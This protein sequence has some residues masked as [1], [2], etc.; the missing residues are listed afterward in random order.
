MVPPEVRS[1][2][3]DPT[4]RTLDGRT[5]TYPAA[6][7]HP[8]RSAAVVLLLSAMTLL[9]ACSDDGRTLREPLDDQTTTTAAAAG[10]GTGSTEPPGAVAGTN[11]FTVRVD[12][13]LPGES[14]PTPLTCEGEDLAPVVTWQNVPSDAQQLALSMTDPDADGFVHWLVVGLDPLIAGVD[15]ADLPA[16][17]TVLRNGDGEAAWAGPCPS[18]GDPAHDYVFT[19]YALADTAAVDTAGEPAAVLSD[20]AGTSLATTTVAGTYAAGTATSSTV[21]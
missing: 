20:L 9:V 21:P 7:L 2:R 18:A 3:G 19:L 1:R 15:G 8:R 11:G 6:V 17:A 14:L 4:G 16:G 13:F 5:Q 10:A 12:G